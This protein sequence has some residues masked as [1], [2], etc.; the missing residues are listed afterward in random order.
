MQTPGHRGLIFLSAIHMTL[1]ESDASESITWP[2]FKC[3]VLFAGIYFWI[4]DW[5]FHENWKV[6]SFSRKS[7]WKRTKM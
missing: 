4:L 7:L 1:N 2:Y 5:L 6:H 3:E